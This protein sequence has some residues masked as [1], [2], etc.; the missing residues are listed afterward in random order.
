MPPV[1]LLV[2]L[3]TP[4]D[5]PADKCTLS[6]TVVNSATGQ[7]LNKVRVQVEAVGDEQAQGFASTDAQGQFAVPNLD[8]G[9]YRIKGQRNGYL[10]TYY[11]ARR[12]ESKGTVIALTPGQSLPDLQL[13]M[14]P[15]AVIAGTVRDADGEPLAK[16]TVTLH[17][18]H[19][20][21]GKRKITTTGGGYTDDL[22]QFRI[23][24]VAPG[25]YYVVAEP[26]QKPIGG[27]VFDLGGSTITFTGGISEGPPQQTKKPATPPDVLLAALAPGVRDTSAARVVDVDPGA[28]VLGVDVTLSRSRTVAVKGRI[29][30]PAGTAV[31]GVQLTHGHEGYDPLPYTFHTGAGPGGEFEFDAVTPGSYM[32]S[33]SITRVQRVELQAQAVA[34]PGAVFF[35]NGSDHAGCHDQLPVQVGS[36]NVEDLHLA[37]SV[38]SEVLGHVTVEGKDKPEGVSGQIWFDDGVRDANAVQ[39]DDAGAFQTELCPGHYAITVNIGPAELLV[40][41]MQSAGRDIL[42]TGLTIAG[43]GKEQLDIVLAHEGGSLDGVALDADDKPVAGATVALVPEAKLRSRVKRFQQT[44]ADQYGRYDFA[45]IPPGDYLVFSWE[46]VEPGIWYDPEF[47]KSVEA[48]GMQVTI[49]PKGHETVKPHVIR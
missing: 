17:R 26:E 48:K 9:R 10:D 28:R 37:M 16:A 20:E 40:H 27:M 6:G 31:T 25:K 7:P 30:A 45:N 8:P 14:M 44:E 35:S 19:Y 24:G 32:L 21:E 15:F 29:V 34:E 11:G 5:R 18:L 33:A 1:L 49:Q 12:A 42:S 39:V 41:S 43:P 36:S 23:A 13:K 46:D 2:L 3:F 4:Q 22:G 38:G 47:L